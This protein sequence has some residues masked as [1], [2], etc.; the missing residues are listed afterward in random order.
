MEIFH[1]FGVE[2]RLLLIQ[3]VNFAVL[4]LAL[5][6]FLYKPMMKLLDE[7][8]QKIEKGVKDA[9]KAA[10]D[11]AQAEDERRAIVASAT[12]QGDE[13]TERARK[14]AQAADKQAQ[15]DAE[16]KAARILLSAEKESEELRAQ[17]LLGAKEEMAKLIVLGVEKTL[18]KN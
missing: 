15:V 12:K 16:A 14:Q 17:A 8:R 18:R 4:M 6:V 3:L 11:L 2:W 13:I 10:H 9:D 5:W 7:R 1:A